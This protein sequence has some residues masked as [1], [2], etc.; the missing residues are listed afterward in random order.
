MLLRPK[1]D[2][3]PKSGELTVVLLV[4]IGVSCNEF[5]CVIEDELTTDGLVVMLLPDKPTL[6]EPA[7]PSSP[8]ALEASGE[9]PNIAYSLRLII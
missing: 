4:V 7:E 1:S 6:A 5:T 3:D 9:N 2:D 8:I